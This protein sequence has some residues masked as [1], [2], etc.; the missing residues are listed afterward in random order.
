[1]AVQYVPIDGER[2][3]REWARQAY[4]YALWRS[5]RGNLAARPSNNAPHIRTGRIDHAIDFSNAG[6]AIAWLRKHGLRATLP[7]RGESWHVEVPASDLREFAADKRDPVIRP[8][9]VKPF[10]H[11]NREAVVRLQRL[12]RNRGFLSVK[13][14]GRYDRRTRSAVGR[15]QHRRGLKA[16]RIVGPTTW[17]ELRA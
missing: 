13:V 9:Y 15:F 3:S 11:N 17:R 12:L 8:Y 2:V 5:G 6:A 7:V 14:N 10:R 1:M 16:D 4:F